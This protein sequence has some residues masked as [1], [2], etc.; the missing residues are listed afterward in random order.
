MFL[1]EKKN[2]GFRSCCLLTNS[3]IVV[4]FLL[5]G[6]TCGEGSDGYELFGIYCR[7]LH[8][9]MCRSYITVIFKPLNV[10]RLCVFFFFF[11]QGFVFQ[12]LKQGYVFQ[13]LK[14]ITC[15]LGYNPFQRLC[16][17]FWNSCYQINLGSALLCNWFLLSFT[18]HLLNRTYVNIILN[19]TI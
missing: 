7:F 5:S 13:I 10:S 15:N 17:R 1:L 18:C 9:R 11:F 8:V 14:H 3:W 19:L 16:F 6:G 12:V 2:F 4:Y